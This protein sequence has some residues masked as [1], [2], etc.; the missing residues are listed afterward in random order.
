MACAPSHEPSFPAS[1]AAQGLWAAQSVIGPSP[2]FTIGQLLEFD[3]RPDAARLIAAATAAA[4]EADL[5]SA[6]FSDDNGELR[7]HLGEPIE[8]RQVDLGPDPSALNSV[9]TTAVGRPIDP[10]IGPCAEISVLTAGNRLGLLIVAHHMV[11]DAY[12]LGLLVRRI[13]RLYDNLTDARALRSITDLPAGVDDARPGDR[14]FWERE[15]GAA[16]GPV[17]LA[18]APRGHRIARGVRTERVVVGGAGSLT[19]TPA[20]LAALIAA[21]CARLVDSDEVILGFPMMNRLGSPA[22]TCACSTVN[23]IP[24]RV[25]TPRHATLSEVATDVAGRI[26]TVSAHARYR[27][28]DIVRDL[29][30]RGIDGVIGPTLNIK[31][32][33][34]TAAIGGHV[35]VIRSLARGPVVDVAITCADLDGDL[36][37]VLDAD[38]DLY[39]NADVADICSG[40]GA[41]VAAATR[42]PTLDE[43]SIGAI[44]MPDEQSAARAIA[45]ADE[46]TRGPIDPTPLVQRVLAHPDDAVALICGDERI[47]VATLRAR[48]TALSDELGVLA[49]EDIVAVALPRGV[50]MIVALLAVHHSGAAFLPLDPGFPAERLAATMADAAPVAV[51]EPGSAATAE[52]R[53]LT[54]ASAPPSDHRGVVSSASPAPAPEHPAYVIYTSG[55][56]GTP[57]GVVISHRALAN[58]GGH[59]A[60]LVGY[61]P[62]RRVLSVTTISFDIAILETLVPLAAGATVILA[63][64]DDVHDPARLAALIRTHRIDVMQATPS[65]WSAFLESGHGKALTDVDVLVGGEALPA[66]IAGEL[67][68]HA[69]SAR[70]MYGPTETTIW[71][72]TEPL[73]RGQTAEVG[74]GTPIAN[75]GVRILNSA[76]HPTTD[77]DV[78]ELYLSGAGLARGYHGRPDLTCTRFVADPFGPPGTRMYCT[79]DLARRGHDGTLHCLGRTDH[80]VKIRGFRIELGDIDAALAQHHSVE[81]AVTVAVDGR[82]VGYAVPTRGHQIDTVSLRRHLAD[83][84]P[85]YMIPTV[86]TAID[87]VPLTPNGKIDRTGLPRPDFAALAGDSREPSSATEHALAQAFREVLGLPAVGV[88]DDFFILGGDSLTAVRVVAHA[89]RAGLRITPIELFDHPT[90]T[91]LATIARAADP[92]HE[93]SLHSEYTTTTADLGV[94]ELDELVEGDLL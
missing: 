29:R 88:E 32:F 21:H 58:F 64:N 77:G 42:A 87:E 20:V 73:R 30:R 31:P 78:G 71:S 69:A 40:I 16:N 43:V 51:I 48:V 2:V 8:V 52:V 13:A 63:T 24:L 50:D 56:T 44:A 57:K 76:L 59:L 83:R 91:R 80:Q 28:E 85:D 34:P 72:T 10:A 26:A 14:E 65:L 27:G 7:F 6:R 92:N 66:D 61:H 41:F 15:L 75:T 86:I 93:A 53:A 70:N 11:L 62:G 23:V 12:G 90:I 67:T 39:G 94:D 74:I 1:A 60:E 35:A 81:R 18:K 4:R 79:G 33:S 82:L 54:P 25:A 84:L 55:S 45:A 46:A 3:T 38:A 47:D 9:A 36:E 68:R 5:L 49:P 89:A 22:A 37:I 19:R 17:T